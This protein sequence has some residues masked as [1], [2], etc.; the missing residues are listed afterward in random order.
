MFGTIREDMVASRVASCK[1]VIV[2]AMQT[3]ETCDCN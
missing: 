3:N 1:G 2:Y